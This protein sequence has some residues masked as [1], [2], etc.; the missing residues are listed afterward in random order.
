MDL[1]FLLDG[2]WIYSTLPSARLDG[3][4]KWIYSTLPSARLDGGST[5]HFPAWMDGPAVEK[6]KVVRSILGTGF[7][8]QGRGSQEDKVA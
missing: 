7:F 3:G 8:D 4:P 2:G 5:V 1:L 6:R